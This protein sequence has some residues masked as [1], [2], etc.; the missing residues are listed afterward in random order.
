M[1]EM[2]EAYANLRFTN[3]QQQAYAYL[4]EQIFSGQLAQGMRLKPDQISRTL[5]IS[6]MPVRDAI[7]QLDAEGLVT[8][9]PNRGATVTSLTPEDILELFEMRAVLE[10][11]AL[12]RALPNIAGYALDDLEALRQ[13]M[14]R[15]RDDPSEWLSRHHDF[16]DAI[17]NLSKAPRLG[18]SVRNLRDA[19]RP[20]LL[21]YFSAFSDSKTGYDHQPIMDVIKAGNADRADIEMQRH[22]MN[23]AHELVRFIIQK[24]AQLNRPAAEPNEGTTEA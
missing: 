24:G 6:R 7:R 10:G 8:I 15:V 22:V 1:R 20:Y 4:R 14:E 3:V 12:R 19:L 17:C 16:H 9:R 21:M 18:G 13:G 11:L 23:H 5:G 2:A